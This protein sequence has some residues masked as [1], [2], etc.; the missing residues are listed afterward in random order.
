[1]SEKKFPDAFQSKFRGAFNTID[2]RY[3]IPLFRGVCFSIFAFS[4]MKDS[5]GRIRLSLGVNPA[6]PKLVFSESQ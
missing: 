1:M 2:S 6:F 3:F 5:S 4:S